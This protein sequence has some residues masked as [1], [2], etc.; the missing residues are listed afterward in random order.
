MGYKLFFLQVLVS[1]AIR[2]RLIR[3][4]LLWITAILLVYRGF[5]FI[6]TSIPDTSPQTALLYSLSSTAFV[7][8]LIIGIYWLI[9][10][11]IH[12]NLL[13]RFKL[14]YFLL[15]I[16]GVHLVAAE[17]VLAHFRLVYAL[18]PLTKLPRF[19]AAHADHIQQLPFWLAPFDAIIVW[20]FSFS[21]VYN[22]LLYAIGL[23]VF[24]DLFT[25]QLQRVELEK[26]NLRLEFDFLKAQVNPHFL[27]NTL[28]NIYS[29]AIRSP[30]RVAGSILKLSDLMRYTLYETNEERVLL[31]KEIAFLTSYVDL[32][33]IRHD[34]HVSIRF[35]V[36]GEST[37]QQVPPLLFISFIENAF[38]HGIQSTAQAS[39]VDIQLHI[40]P[41]AVTLSVENSRPERKAAGPA[42]IG[43]LN[44]Q[45]RLAF[46]Y[47][48]L[49]TLDIVSTPDQFSVHLSLHLHETD[50]SRHYPG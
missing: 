10:W 2:F 28:N 23:K 42:G 22:Y 30:E 7:S 47:P 4:A 11:Q 20:L 9:T 43:L 1:P 21:L 3:H 50:L 19:Y 26:E 27:F 44:V 40:Q 36:T 41:A 17:L 5:R 13:L 34:D 8:T 24:K 38:K 32:E 15:A 29:F 14:N 12:Q 35:S 49:H 6:A 37:N 39:W 45:K 25:S 33:R 46:Y 16:L 31:S 48:N 18:F